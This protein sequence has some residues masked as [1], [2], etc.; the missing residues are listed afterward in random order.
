MKKLERQRQYYVESQAT[1]KDILWLDKLFNL[2]PSVM[3]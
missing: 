3:T 2:S 1:E